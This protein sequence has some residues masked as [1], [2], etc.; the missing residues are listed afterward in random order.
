MEVGGLKYQVLIVIVKLDSTKG[1]AVSPRIETKKNM[2]FILV[3]NKGIHEDDLNT[4]DNLHHWTEILY[5]E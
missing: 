2:Y 3:L 4:L 5:L 1:R